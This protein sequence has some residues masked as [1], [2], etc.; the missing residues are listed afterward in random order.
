[1]DGKTF[2]GMGTFFPA[3][4]AYATESQGAIQNRPQEHLSSTDTAIARS[5]QMLLRAIRA[6]Q[7]GGEA[8]HL[9][10]DAS[11]NDFSHLVVLS[12]IIPAAADWRTAWQQTAAPATLG[13]GR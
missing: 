2:T 13:A 12:K 7:A 4:D 5:R 9:V 1:M 8:P 3:H 6:V 11:A 10:R